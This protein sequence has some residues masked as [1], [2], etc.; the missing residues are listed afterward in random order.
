MLFLLFW[1][2]LSVTTQTI[3]GSI[4]FLLLQTAASSSNKENKLTQN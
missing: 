3:Q 2:P 1:K 4:L